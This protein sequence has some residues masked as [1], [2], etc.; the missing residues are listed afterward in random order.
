MLTGI[1]AVGIRQLYYVFQLNSCFHPTTEDR[2]LS[3]SGVVRY[4]IMANALSAVDQG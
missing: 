2:G 4:N 3:R 1:I